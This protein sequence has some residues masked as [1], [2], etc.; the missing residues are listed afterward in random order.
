MSAISSISWAWENPAS[1]FRIFFDLA[2]VGLAQ[3][4]RPGLVTAFNP[5]LERMLGADLHRS[6]ILLDLI[7]PEDRTEAERQLLQLFDGMRES[8]QIESAANANRLPLC[9]N[10]WRV[11]SRNGHADSALAMLEE[12]PRTAALSQRF[13]Q[14]ARLES[15]GKLA[16]GVAHDFNNILTGVLLYCD[17]MIATLEPGH[18]SRKYAEE[19][20]KATM[21]SSD[22]VR[23]L[24]AIARPAVSRAEPLC[25]NEVAQR[26]RGLL[27]RLVGDKVQLTFRFDPNLGLIKLDATQAQQILLNLVLNA[28]DAMPQ[29]GHILLE[30]R[31]C[32]LQAVSD[33][34]LGKNTDASLPCVLLIVEDDGCGMDAGTRSHIF[35]PFFTTKLEKG[36]GLGLTTVLEIVNCNGGLIDV[37]SEPAQGTRVS[38]LFPVVPGSI[39]ETTRNN[40]FPPRSS[41][42]MLSSQDEE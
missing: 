41:G 32:K 23:Q 2:P 24:L 16:G 30:T 6:E 4:R 25:L 35:E 27:L 5:A 8:I 17:L 18:R 37:S 9:W 39:S 28:R 7:Q 14:A 26:M 38:V 19:I 40:D 3:C 29:G 36:T 31:N 34:A 1:E 21:Q 33:S 13:Q 10:V 42:G 15:L 11:S 20:R 12:V 22:L